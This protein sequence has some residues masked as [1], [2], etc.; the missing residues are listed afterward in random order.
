MTAQASALDILRRLM[1]LLTAKDLVRVVQAPPF[2]NLTQIEMHWE[3][4]GE[5]MDEADEFVKR[6]SDATKR[7]Q[8][9]SE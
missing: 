6:V 9:N 3:K 8:S 1:P 7:S 4:L 2:G 5:V